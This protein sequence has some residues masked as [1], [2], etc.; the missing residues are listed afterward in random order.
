MRKNQKAQSGF[1]LIELIIVV[2]IIGILAAVA[3]PKFV[4]M[5]TDASAATVRGVAGTLSSASTI[6]YSSRLM[7]PSGAAYAKSTPIADCIDV[8]NALEGGVLPTGYF[9]T[10]Q[11]ISPGATQTCT[12]TGPVEQGSLTA[13]FKAI[14][15][16]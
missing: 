15:T 12:V 9:I 11:A 6:N 13:T 3:V 8:S 7:G 5:S 1:T 14:G 16:N 4:D 10:P 2:V